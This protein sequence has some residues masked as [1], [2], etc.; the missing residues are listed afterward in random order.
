MRMY[1]KLLGKKKESEPQAYRP[2]PTAGGIGHD[3]VTYG[4]NSFREL[5]QDMKRRNSMQRRSNL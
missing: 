4:K 2:K 1:E 3:I 5:N